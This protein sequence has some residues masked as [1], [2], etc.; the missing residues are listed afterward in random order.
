MKKLTFCALFILSCYFSFAQQAHQ[1]EFGFKSDN[2]VYISISQDQYYTNG[3]FIFYRYIAKNSS[4]KIIKKINEFQIVQLMYNSFSHYVPIKEDQD[5]PFAGYSFVQF[6]KSY[7]YKDESIFKAGIQVGVLG[8]SS[9]ARDAQITYHRI[10][11]LPQIAGWK[12]QIHDTFGLNFNAMYVNHFTYFAS[13]KMDISGLANA[14]VGTIFNDISI[15]FLTRLT[16]E[17]RLNPLVESNYFGAQIGNKNNL[18]PVKEF[19]FYLQP[20][21]SYVAYN[22]TIQGSLFSNSSPVTFNVRPI[23]TSIEIGF[24][25]AYKRF[26]F[27]YGL[28]YLTK[29]VD[30]N[31][32][33]NHKYG[34][35]RIGYLF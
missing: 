25:Y 19:Y 8:P 5:R 2:D 15:G 6:N 23:T 3:L 10:F 16:F 33:K 20:K 28:H 11:G 34:T 24:K 35:I 17:K 18:L 13:D 29:T 12:Y 9:K 4:S 26:N 1:H 27:N 22:A 7:F 14:N 32:V 31:S 21:I 30:N